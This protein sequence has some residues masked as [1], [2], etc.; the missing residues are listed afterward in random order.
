MTCSSERGALYESGKRD[1]VIDYSVDDKTTVTSR[2]IWKRKSQFILIKEHLQFQMG[3]LSCK[4]GK[5]EIQ[6]NVIVDHG[7]QFLQSK[8]LT[9]TTFSLENFY[10]S[11]WR[12]KGR[13][14]CLAGPCVDSQLLLSQNNKNIILLLVLIQNCQ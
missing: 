14:F 3:N 1:K 9:K 12:S 4:K 6:N 7:K 2:L 11:V 13:Q 8:I 5:K 10:I